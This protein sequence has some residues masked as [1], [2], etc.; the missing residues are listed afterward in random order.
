MVKMEERGTHRLQTRLAPVPDS[1]AGDGSTAS[2][3]GA[4]LPGIDTP[5][6]Y[7][8]GEKDP[9]SRGYLGS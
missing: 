2:N 5:G 4:G 8:V 3:R 9:H 1:L 7:Y 6:Y